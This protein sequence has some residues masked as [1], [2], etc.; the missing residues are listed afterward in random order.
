M[1]T[2]LICYGFGNMIYM[3]CDLSCLRSEKEYRRR[4]GSN[5]IFEG[6]EGRTP[7]KNRRRV[8]LK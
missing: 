2:V 1:K 8:K 4:E 5:T 3:L 6:K 7:I